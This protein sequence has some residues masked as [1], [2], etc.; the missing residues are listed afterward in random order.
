MKKKKK[1]MMIMMMMMGAGGSSHY[2]Q[3]DAWSLSY[4]SQSP[5]GRS[6]VPSDLSTELRWIEMTAAEVPH[7]DHQGLPDAFLKR[8]DFNQH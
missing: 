4:G 7:H 8:L 3:T 1:M 6:V 5:C 2:F